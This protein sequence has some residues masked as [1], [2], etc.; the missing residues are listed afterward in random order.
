MEPRAGPLRGTCQQFC[1]AS[2]ASTR[3][4]HAL[5]QRPPAFPPVKCFS[6]SSAGSVVLPEECRPEPVLCAAVAHLLRAV[7]AHPELALQDGLVADRLRAVRGDGFVQGLRSLAWCAALA[8]QV[9]YHLA[10]AYFLGGEVLGGGALGGGST[11]S[12]SLSAHENGERLSEALGMARGA[13]AALLEAEAEAQQQEGR[14]AAEALAL[15]VLGYALVLALPQPVAVRGILAQAAPLAR[16]APAPARAAWR[17]VVGPCMAWLGGRWP[18]FLRLV[19]ALGGA[20]AAEAAAPAPAPSPALFFA[21]CALHRLVPLA[22]AQ[23]LAAVNDALGTPARPPTLP[24]AAVTAALHC[25]CGGGSA[26]L[27]SGASG[28]AIGGA[29]S[30][31]VSGGSGSGSSGGGQGEPAWFRAARFAAQLG[32]SVVE[33]VPSGGACA[34]G[35]VPCPAGRLFELRVAWGR[36]DAGAP[37]AVGALGVVLNKA[38]RLAL[39]GSPC[40]SEDALRAA[41][42]LTPLRED[43]DFFPLGACGARTVG[44]LVDLINA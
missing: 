25:G 23:L 19:A 15:E 43:A 12:G 36:G 31:C 6:R 35:S 39:G 29:G 5:E 32:L 44:A 41:V 24:L 9:R 37:E 38:T 21:R 33:A 13:L 27:G 20:C 22:R 28:G 17:C 4:L 8:R 42:A 3:R 1:S 40:S 10:A 11:A 14:A 18:E 30:S 2:E 34:G 7:L 26:A 16:S